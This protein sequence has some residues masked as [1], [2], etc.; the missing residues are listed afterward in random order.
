[1]ARRGGAAAQS[2]LP[3]AAIIAVLLFLAVV[4]LVVR[5][6]HHLPGPCPRPPL[7]PLLPAVCHRRPLARASQGCGRCQRWR[8]PGFAGSA[9]GVPAPRPAGVWPGPETSMIRNGPVLAF[10]GWRRR[11]LAP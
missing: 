9:T 10:G 5:S 8:W 3:V 6:S 7:R 2:I 1:M 4:M 11:Y